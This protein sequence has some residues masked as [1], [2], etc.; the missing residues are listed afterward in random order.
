MRIGTIILAGA[1]VGFL[2][3]ATV[4]LVLLG[5]PMSIIKPLAWGALGLIALFLDAVLLVAIGL[6]THWWEGV[7]TAL[8]FIA[9]G[10]AFLYFAVVPW[11][12]EQRFTIA[13][14]KE[15]RDLTFH[16]S[17]AGLFGFYSATIQLGTTSVR[18]INVHLSPL[19]MRRGG[20]I[21]QA[22]KAFT[23]AE[24]KH[25]AEIEAI[26]RTIDVEQPSIIVG[27][28]NSLS[29]FKAPK[30]LLKL[31]F[32]DAFA[33]MHADADAR[34]TWHWPTKPMPLAFRID[35]IFHSPHFTTAKSE[36]IRRDGSDHHLVFADL[37]IVRDTT[38]KV[39][40]RSPARDE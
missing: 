29:T 28:F 38:P 25:A 33:S 2:V 4:Q 16:P 27:D 5:C 6:K 7:C 36:V 3:A 22:I 21:R 31:G 32:R 23:D 37:N 40:P 19:L 13:S 17:D 26:V 24:E 1:G 34:P 9:V 8:G 30:R 15:L 20:G 35:Y 18:I 10:M 11:A 12:A 39:T 14:K